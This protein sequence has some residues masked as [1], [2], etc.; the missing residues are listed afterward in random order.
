M[1]KSHYTE[2]QIHRA[3]KQLEALQIKITSPLCQCVD[4]DSFTAFVIS[5]S[6]AFDGLF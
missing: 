1:R 2:E 5:D 6:K 3:V 4:N